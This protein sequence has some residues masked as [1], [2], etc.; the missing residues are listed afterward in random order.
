MQCISVK[1]WLFSVIGGASAAAGAEGH[2]FIHPSGMRAVS[3]RFFVC[4]ARLLTV[5]G[6][7]LLAYP[8]NLLSP[9]SWASNRS[10]VAVAAWV[11]LLAICGA[12][13]GFRWTLDRLGIAKGRWQLPAFAALVAAL[14]VFGQQQVLRGFVVPQTA[15]W[16]QLVGFVVRMPLGEFPE[17]RLVFRK[18]HWS[19]P[20]R[21]PVRDEFF[22]PSGVSDWGA[23]G[24]V[25]MAIARGRADADEWQFDLVEWD[26]AEAEADI[27]LGTFVPR[28]Y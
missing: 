8:P 9:E 16:A 19:M 25:R 14:A 28:A 15:E 27:D 5:F 24:M 11:W 7:L 23:A 3:V 18:A 12:A 10:L 21:L 6:I 4:P 20:P 13:G 22:L 17:R 1:V 2:G 26:D